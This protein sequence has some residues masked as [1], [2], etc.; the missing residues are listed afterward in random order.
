MKNLARFFLEKVD[1][2]SDFD[3]HLKNAITFHVLAEIFFAFLEVEDAFFM[4]FLQ[5][6]SELCFMFR[7]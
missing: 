5:M 6:Q 4:Q 2:V 1:N 7:G 3:F